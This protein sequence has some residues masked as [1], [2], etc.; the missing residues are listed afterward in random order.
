MIGCVNFVDEEG[1][2]EETGSEDCWLDFGQAPAEGRRERREL[3]LRCY[4]SSGWSF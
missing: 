1:V 2:E 3:W 4:E